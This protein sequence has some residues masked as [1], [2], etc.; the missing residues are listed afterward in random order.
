[1]IK[2]KRSHRKYMLDTV[3]CDCWEMELQKNKSVSFIRSVS[4]INTLLQQHSNTELSLGKKSGLWIQPQTSTT[5]GWPSSQARYFITSWWLLQ[6]IVHSTCF[7]ISLR[8]P[9]RFTF[10]SKTCPPCL[11]DPALTNS[12]KHIRASGSSWTTPQTSSTSPIRSSD[13]EQVGV[14]LF[15]SWTQK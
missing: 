10:T 12:R 15:K 2:R 4:T 1:M 13:Q 6:G 3:C 11:S 14:W 7:K 9:L 8:G 5:D